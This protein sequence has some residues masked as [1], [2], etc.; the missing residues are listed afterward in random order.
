MG[1]EKLATGRSAV[2]NFS[3]MEENAR[4]RFYVLSYDCIVIFQTVICV[5][6]FLE[7]EYR[8]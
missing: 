5:G 3:N 4:R 8:N 6:V 2:Y 1:V 7:K